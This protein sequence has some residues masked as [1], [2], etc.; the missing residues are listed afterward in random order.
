[1]IVTID[2]TSASG[3]STTAKEVAR[4]LGFVYIDT[5]AMYRAVALYCI[6]NRIDI[7]NRKAVADVSHK[8]DIRF[9]FGND[10]NHIFLNNKKVTNLIRTEEVGSVASTI[11]TYKYVRRNL[12]EKQREMGRKENVICEGRDIGTVVFKDADVKIYMDA[13]LIERAQRRQRELERTAD[14]QS[15]IESLKK[16][17]EQ[18]KMRVES[19]LKIPEDAVIIDTTHLSIEDE[20]E[21]VIEVIRQY[22]YDKKDER[23]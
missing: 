20:V 3:K 21:K 7:H 11:A 15:V 16:R 2:G 10:K 14:L 8:I 9:E 17:D 23:R 18:D 4:K 5:G 6:E 22:E 1:M 13:D 12:V 19:P